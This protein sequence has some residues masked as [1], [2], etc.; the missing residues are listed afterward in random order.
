[1]RSDTHFFQ[2]TL[3]VII[4][5]Y[6]AK[7][8]IGAC[9]AHARITSAQ[10]TLSRCTWNGFYGLIN[11]KET[12]CE[13]F[14]DLSGACISPDRRFETGEILTIIVR[15]QA[16]RRLRANDCT[17]F[18]CEVHVFRVHDVLSVIFLDIWS[19]YS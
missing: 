4:R 8:R 16:R 6:T 10:K 15:A 14:R 1:M 19:T 13:S 9:R 2:F 3:S 7:S 11:A 18:A 5:A 12:A 17:I